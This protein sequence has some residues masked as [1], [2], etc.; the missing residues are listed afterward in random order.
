LA[1]DTGRENVAVILASS[2]ALRPEVFRSFSRVE[3]AG[4]ERTVIATL[5]TADDP[6]LVGPTELG[7][8]EPAFRRLGQPDGAE[9][10][11]SPVTPPNSLDAVRRKIA[12]RT[13]S[14]TDIGAIVRDLTTYR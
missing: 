9:I 8:A 2:L 10:T 1:L 12:G 6:G 4:S 11:L 7:L 5:M 14:S 3:I 13:L